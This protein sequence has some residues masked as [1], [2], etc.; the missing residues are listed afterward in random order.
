MLTLNDST[1]DEYHGCCDLEGSGKSTLAE[2]I[3]VSTFRLSIPIGA[4][5]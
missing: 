4:I 2:K 1:Y 3:F 5:G